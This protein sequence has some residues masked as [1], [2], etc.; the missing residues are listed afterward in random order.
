MKQRNN[1][2]ADSNIPTPHLP[3]GLEDKQV[4]DIS[5]GF[6]ALFDLPDVNA[7]SEGVDPKLKRCRDNTTQVLKWSL[8]VPYSS[9]NMYSVL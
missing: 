2:P 6:Y 9:L 4:T 7:T 3:S 5:G 8:S 1:A